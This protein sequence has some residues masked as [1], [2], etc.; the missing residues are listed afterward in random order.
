MPAKTAIDE[1][2]QTEVT[3]VAT[4]A[5]ATLQLV[6]AF[7]IIGFVQIPAIERYQADAQRV[8]R[9]GEAN[10]RTNHHVG[11]VA[12]TVE[13]IDKRSIRQIGRRHCKR[14][15]HRDRQSQCRRRKCRGSQND[16]RQDAAYRRAD[17]REIVRWSEVPA[18]RL[19]HWRSQQGV[20]SREAKLLS[21]L[22][23][24]QT[25]RSGGATSKRKL[26][27]RLIVQRPKYGR[28]GQRP[29]SWPRRRKHDSRAAAKRRTAEQ[30]RV[31]KVKAGQI[32]RIIY[33]DSAIA[34][35]LEEELDVIIDADVEA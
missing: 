5:G 26:Y 21:N 19:D 22:T 27:E 16:S 18:V 17:S 33:F 6:E 1:T 35:G 12:L 14:Q 13:T 15:R 28:A 8:V 11:E 20:E 24:G 4:R 29:D 9:S 34:I 25:K 2:N 3:D 31:R 32:L 10:L 30:L 7:E 23:G